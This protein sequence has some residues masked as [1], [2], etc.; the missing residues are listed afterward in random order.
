[1][2]IPGTIKLSST[3]AS[4]MGTLGGTENHPEKGRVSRSTNTHIRP[5]P[6]SHGAGFRPEGFQLWVCT[7]ILCGPCHPPLWNVPHL[8]CAEPK[9]PPGHAHFLTRRG[10]APQTPAP[11]KARSPEAPPSRAPE[12]PQRM[13]VRDRDVTRASLVR[14]AV[15]ARSRSRVA[16]VSWCVAVAV[17]VSLP[18]RAAPCTTAAARSGTGP[19]RER[20]SWRACGPTP[21]AN[22][23]A[24]RWLTGR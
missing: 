22:S 17:L 2:G 11:P 10:H 6:R 21:T 1:M 19:L 18:A 9:P 4:E 13:P 5:P 15:F 23:S 16:A 12:T 7:H 14:V 8:L 24:K 3:L 20:S